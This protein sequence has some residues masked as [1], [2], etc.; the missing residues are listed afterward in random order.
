MPTPGKDYR[1]SA[2][3]TV[4]Y[5]L[6]EFNGIVWA[7]LVTAVTANA[8]FFVYLTIPVI[9][10]GDNLHWAGLKTGPAGNTFVFYYPGLD[11][12]PVLK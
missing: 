11:R 4:Q 12:H 9:N 2:Y 7:H 1:L 8:A 3:Y 10:N 6:T 5:V